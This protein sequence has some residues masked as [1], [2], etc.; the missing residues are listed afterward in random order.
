MPGVVRTGPPL[1]AHLPSKAEERDGQLREPGSSRLVHLEG[2]SMFF[3]FLGDWLAG[4]Q[5]ELL[6]G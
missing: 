4:E 2:M 6:Q 5:Q 1:D 3:T